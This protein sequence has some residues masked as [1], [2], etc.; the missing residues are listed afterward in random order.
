[1]HPRVDRR[2][3]AQQRHVDAAEDCAADVTQPQAVL[4]VACTACQAD[5]R[6][7]Y[8]LDGPA[9]PYRWQA[10]SCPICDGHNSLNLAGHI[11]RIL[12]PE[13]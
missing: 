7:E 13:S 4:R 6:L 2:R 5:L 10:W 3:P 9:E 11:V 1:M 8:Q 12:I